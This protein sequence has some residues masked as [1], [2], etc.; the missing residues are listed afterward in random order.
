MLKESFIYLY[1]WF[2]KWLWLAFQ[3]HVLMNQECIPFVVVEHIC[4]VMINHRSLFSTVTGY[5]VDVRGSISGRERV[6]SL[7]QYSQTGSC[8]QPTS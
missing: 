7:R 4:C 2:M 5:G 3:S 1:L 6:F 8:A